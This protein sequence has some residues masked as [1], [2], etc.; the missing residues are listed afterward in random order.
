MESLSHEEIPQEPANRL[1]NV[2][3]T[4]AST[5]VYNDFLTR[6]PGDDDQA[7]L[8]A[9]NSPHAEDWLN[10]PTNASVGLRLSDGEIRVAFGYRLRS[11]TCLPH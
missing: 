4:V 9:A 6:C 3:D 1:H 2:W 5:A 11:S 10:A 7:R 8:K